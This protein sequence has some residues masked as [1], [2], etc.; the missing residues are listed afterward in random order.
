MLTRM[1]N[2][3]SKGLGGGCCRSQA[4]D[5]DSHPAEQNAEVLQNTNAFTTCKDNLSLTFCLNSTTRQREGR[6]DLQPSSTLYPFFTL[7]RY[8]H[9]PTHLTPPPLGAKRTLII[10]VSKPALPT[11]APD[12]SPDLTAGVEGQ[13]P[14]LPA[15]R[16]SRRCCGLYRMSRQFGLVLKAAA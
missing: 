4:R 8:G 14:A 1:G 9:S 2:R 10:H 7:T 3:E 13:D 11:L 12:H 16:A 6:T 5:G 15:S